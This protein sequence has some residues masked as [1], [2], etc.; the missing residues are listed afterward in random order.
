MTFTNLTLLLEAAA[1]Q[2]SSGHVVCYPLRNT[3]KPHSWSYRQL[4]ED[5]QKASW[6]LR[7][8][9]DFS[10]GRVVLI[11]LDTHW[12]NIV[13]FWA[14]SL[15]GCIPAMSTTLS[16]NPSA[17]ISH[18][19][20]LATTFKG[21]SCLTT[22]NK[23][24]EFGGQ[25][26]ITP[27]ALESLAVDK[28]PDSE[29]RNICRNAKP[30]DI[31]ILML[32]S[33]STSH[34][35]AV[36][37]THQQIFL[38]L[39][40]KYKVVPLPENTSFLN[41]VHCD[42]VAAIV[43]IHLQ[44]LFAHKDQVHVHASDVLSHPVAFL[45]IIDRHRVSRTFAPNFFL[46]RIRTALEDHGNHCT[47][48][49]WDLSCLRYIASGGEA[50]VTKT[51]AAVVKL[52]TRYGAPEST[53]A[54][55]FGM[56][57]TC[58]G[59]IYNLDFPSYDIKQGLEFASAGKCIRGLNMRIRTAENIIAPSGTVG[60]LELSGPILFKGYFNNPTA[61]EQSF[62]S[63]GWFQ[64][65]DLASVDDKGNLHMIGRAKESMI[66]NGVKY[67]PQEIETA[68]DQP[69]EIPGLVPSFTCC[70][71]S[72]P[73]GG[74]T[75]IICVVYLPS[76][77]PDDNVAR[78]KTADAIAKITMMTTGARPEVLPLDKLQLQ[79]SALGKLSR[80]KIKSA[81]EKGD[82][83][84]Y[85]ELNSESIKLHRKTAR[86]NPSNELEEKLLDL[87]LVSLELPQEEFD[88]QS[89][90]FDMGITSV[91]LIKLKKKIEEHLN[92]AHEIPIITLMTNPTVR[93]LASA[94]K[95]QQ[96]HQKAGE[97]SPTVT[98][99]SQGQKTPL[100][101]VHP[102]VGEVLVFLNL[103]KFL[104]DR[105]VYALRARGFN[106]GEEPFASI[107]E[108]VS[109]YHA[110]IKR[111]QPHGPYALAGY[112]YGTMLAFE[113]G[114]VLEN[115]GDEVRFLGSF[116]LPPHIKAR[117]RQLDYR[118]CLLHLSYFLDLITEDRARELAV[119]LKDAT[120]EDT[121]AKVMVEADENRLAELALSP[122]AITK[123]ACLAFAL[124]S[125]AVDYDPV[126]SIAGIDVFYCNP[127]AVAAA[128]KAQWVSEH[129][130]QWKDFSRSPPRFHDVGGAHYTMIGPE[131]VFGFQKT[132][133]NALEARGI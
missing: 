97:Y 107:E 83:K 88:V 42:H 119:E 100:W 23:M 39:D 95:S 33:G 3:T 113:V 124:Q 101:L 61:N 60:N 128:S 114:K 118:E 32:T 49:D 22:A 69:G 96:S 1:N 18:L 21:P 75:E 103:A 26:A 10:P 99:Q 15:A 65:G 30:D 25:D 48:Y 76:Y 5:A 37:L 86:A 55:G 19:T 28:A 52:L 6:A 24:F 53:I 82:Y 104:A 102:G 131:H 56:T 130:S 79:K 67:S 70:F 9:P 73:S 90:L 31:A 43:E 36:I 50:N 108:V 80:S 7:R 41:W 57:E 115:N 2:E 105:K 77:A 91:E 121:L 109:T 45:D 40:S 127:L 54:T 85:Q 116:N 47:T 71:S 120:R 63:D 20:H 27:I 29:L 81:F 117:M 35:K 17:R 84:S 4:L 78:A 59:A 64:T 93:D 111:E 58:G 106:E 110:A 74:D 98:L 126:S 129:L 14:V 112:S 13:W 66:V 8:R 89:S 132:L 87:F 62:T 16:N 133:R 51:G 12:E 94:L 11:H 34:A 72:F 125:M 123:W 44:A 38:A 68:L 92:L 122:E 46:A